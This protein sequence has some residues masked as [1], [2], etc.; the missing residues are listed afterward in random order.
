MKKVG[1]IVVIILIV[2]VVIVVALQ[3]PSDTTN[4]D[5]KTQIT[6]ENL[7]DAPDFSL[8]DYD[9][10]V[11]S[12]DDFNGKVLVINSWATWCPF[13]VTELPDFVELQE[14]FGNKIVVIAIDRRESLTTARDF[15]DS[16]EISDDIIFLLDSNDS[17]YQSIGGFSMPETLF[18]NTDG[19]ITFHKR[20]FMTLTEMRQRTEAVLKSK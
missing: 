20:G 7:D 17:F 2:I 8:P 15:T 5:E 1:F 12:L 18:I 9:G 3:R 19:D 13:C 4:N 14:E 10:N 16:L 6:K 11:V